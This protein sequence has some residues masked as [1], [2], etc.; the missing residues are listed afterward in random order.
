MLAVPD[1]PV[2]AKREMSRVRLPCLVLKRVI[3]HERLIPVLL[4]AFVFLPARAEEFPAAGVPNF[5]RVNQHVYRGGQPTDTG[6]NSLAS[7]GVKT[8]VDLRHKGRHAAR[9]EERAVQ[10]AGMRYVNVAMNAILAPRHDKITQ[11]LTLLDSNSEGPVFLHC[12]RGADRTGT[13]IACYRIAHDHWRNGE[14]LR[15]AR[16]YGMSPLQLRM[17]S[18]ILKFR[19][20]NGRDAAG[21]CVRVADAHP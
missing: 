10:A 2:K 9:M 4:L 11:V 17:K 12:R 14:A 21:R 8:I 1:G 18:Y 15:E 19:G 5:H 3:G 6:W 20:E 16:S 13:V 7:M